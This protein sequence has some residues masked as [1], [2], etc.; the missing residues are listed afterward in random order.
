MK[1]LLFAICFLPSIAFAAPFVK[2]D[3][4]DPRA[5]H[6]GWTVDAT[7]KVDLPVLATPTGNICNYDLASISVGAHTIKATAVVLDPVWGRLES[8]DSIPLSLSKPGI[9]L[10]PA[11]LGLKP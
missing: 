8:A 1:K 6:C 11:G 3:P 5:T 2:S 4:L 7:P 9:P 10:V